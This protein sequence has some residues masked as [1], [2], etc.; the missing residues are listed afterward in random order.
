VLIEE[1]L[2]QQL[3]QSV[4]E[5]AR[6][7]L[8]IGW[9]SGGV[10]ANALSKFAQQIQGQSAAKTL[11]ELLMPDK[12]IMLLSETPFAVLAP[13]A[14]NVFDQLNPAYVLLTRPQAFELLLTSE[15]AE[16][17]KNIILNSPFE[18]RLLGTFST[19]TVRDFG[20]TN[21]VSFGINHLVNQGVPINSII[22]ILMLPLIATILAF[23]RQVIGIKAFGLVTPTITALA[24]LVMGLPAGLTVFAAVL[25]SGTLTRV[26]LRRL[27]LLYLPRMALVLTTISLAILV[28]LGVSLNLNALVPRPFAIFPSLQPIAFSI[29]PSLILI[30]LAEEFIALQFKSG[31]RTALTT[32]FWTLAL[33]IITYYIVSWELLRTLLLSYPEIILLTIPA[34]LALGRWGGLRLTEYFRFRYLFRHV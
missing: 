19:R 20:P 24:F 13:I 11:S 30:I 5:I 4:P 3:L 23:A 9:T 10:A 29:F 31:A 7:D 15:D 27:R 33:A 25:V 6:A 28:L 2:A 26:L 34:N 22:L 17:A 21:F 18:F 32:T 1:D 12:G 8:I 16:R 14:Q